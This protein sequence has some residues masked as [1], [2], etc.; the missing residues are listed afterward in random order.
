LASIEAAQTAVALDPNAAHGYFAM[1]LAETVIGRCE[2]SSAHI[3]Q[4]LA[5]SPR[6]PIFGGLWLSN[7][8]LSEACLGRLDAAIGEIK[9]ARI[10]LPSA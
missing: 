7:L 4:A 3:K 2:Q 8:G 9:Q 1:A 5:L 6:D 10:Q